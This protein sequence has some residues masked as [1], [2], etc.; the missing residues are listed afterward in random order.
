MAKKQTSQAAAMRANHLRQRGFH[1]DALAKKW[2][3][4]ARRL[5]S[6]GL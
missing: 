2:D 1:N 6:K 5:A 4:I 3:R